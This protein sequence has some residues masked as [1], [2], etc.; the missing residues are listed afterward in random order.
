[1]MLDTYILDGHRPVL[2]PDPIKWALGMRRV[3]RRVAQ[4]VV[5][6]VRVSTVFLGID[7]RFLDTKGPPLVFE[8]MVFGGPLDQE[9]LRYSTWEEAERGHAA[10]V[11]RATK[12]TS[13]P[14]QMPS[15]D[16]EPPW[17]D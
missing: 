15:D 2:E 4:D 10:M 17:W 13:P 5:G 1:M 6:D 7:H 14:Y 8:T 16:G 11:D 3:D 9:Q 12:R